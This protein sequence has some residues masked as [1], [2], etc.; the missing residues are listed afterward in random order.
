MHDVL[1]LPAARLCFGLSL[2]AFAIDLAGAA[3]APFRINWSFY[4][5][6]AA[7]AV[8][9][10]LL[11]AVLSVVVARLEGD[12]APAAKVISAVC[13]RSFEV[14][15]IIAVTV[16][17]GG[18]AILMS[19]LAASAGFPMQDAVFSGT[20]MALG[21]HWEGF[22]ARLNGSPE[23]VTLLIA[24][25]KSVAITVP[26]S[27][28]FFLLTGRSRE[29]W[30][31]IALIMLGAFMT[32]VISCFVPAIGG[33]TYYG[34]DPTSTSEF[35][36]QWP[37]AGTYFVDG[38][39]EVHSR[40]FETL[41]LD[42]V[43]GIVQFPSFHAILA[44]I[45]IFATRHYPP[46]FWPMLAVNLVMLVSTVPVGGHHGVDVLGSVAVVLA[47]IAIVDAV[48]GRPARARFA[49]LLNRRN[50]L[51]SN[52]AAVTLREPETLS[53]ENRRAN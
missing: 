48:E 24:S 3:L 47:S 30:E 43:V 46:L 32:I 26:L 38:L 50:E 7:V 37:K 20:D 39:L 53:L 14:C 12:S 6:F 34:P 42:R 8:A 22:V 51:V 5:D 36:R 19:A 45:L 13:R 18:A 41:E 27:I 11:A 31:F 35:L 9:V 40:L 49:R 52:W 44:L 29:L 23:L 15:A 28:M 25:Y 1:R 10:P 33:Y 21:F 4:Y 17:F 16:V 2:L